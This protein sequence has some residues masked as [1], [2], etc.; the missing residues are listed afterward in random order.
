LLRKQTKNRN[1]LPI[2]LLPWLHGYIFTIKNIIL[3]KKIPK[4][5]MFNQLFELM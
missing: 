4:K 5:N 2:I 3:Q 1:S